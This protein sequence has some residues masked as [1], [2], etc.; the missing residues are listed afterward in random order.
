MKFLCWI[1]GHDYKLKFQRVTSKK[2]LENTYEC[3]RCKKGILAKDRKF[4]S[5]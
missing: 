5:D 4:E 3:K 2:V 1:K